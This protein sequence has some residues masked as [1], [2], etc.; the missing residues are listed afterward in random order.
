MTYFNKLW[1]VAVTALLLPNA[2]QAEDL[3][4]DPYVGAGLG[5]FQLSTG[6][7]SATVPGGFVLLGAEVHPYV[8]PEIRVGKA[9][10]GTTTGYSSVALDWF[11]SYLLRL[12]A[13]VSE[14]TMLYGLVG[15]TTMRTA[16]TP[17]AGTKISDTSTTFS[18]GLGID[19]RPMRNVSVAAEWVRYGRGYKAAS[20]RGLNVTGISGLLKYS[21]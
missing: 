7:N 16:L 2:A 4:F 8:A 1:A 19:Y 11:A 5:Q 18:F 17:T 13:P 3:Y 14:D 21:F 20:T 10:K 9:N 6:N 15:G 12:Q